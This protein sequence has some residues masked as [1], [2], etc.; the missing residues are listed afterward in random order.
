MKITDSFAA[1][2]FTMAMAAPDKTERK[3][4]EQTV[5]DPGTADPEK[6]ANSAAGPTTGESDVKATSIRQMLQGLQ[7]TIGKGG[8]LEGITTA[9]WD[10]LPILMAEEGHS[11]DSHRRNIP[12]EASEGKGE[13]D[14]AWAPLFTVVNLLGKG[15]SAITL[16]ESTGPVQQQGSTQPENNTDLPVTQP[17]G[18][19][20]AAAGRATGNFFEAPAVSL[21]AK[22]A[23]SLR[24]AVTGIEL[25][26]GNFGKIAASAMKTGA[27]AV[28]PAAKEE[29]RAS[30]DTLSSR[31]KGTDSKAVDI[32][33]PKAGASLPEAEPSS[34]SRGGLT[35]RRREMHTGPRQR[36]PHCPGRTMSYP[37]PAT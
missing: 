28:I 16:P 33:M 20:Q 13:T 37:C 31:T 5:A 6:G 25:P 22:D 19:L 24:A 15:A 35:A 4:P 11:A 14:S 8:S 17:V 1:G 29:I 27:D 36:T 9:P 30:S 18:L 32:S 7:Q 23:D 3:L 12:R 34:R 21:P 26:P 2:L 10:A